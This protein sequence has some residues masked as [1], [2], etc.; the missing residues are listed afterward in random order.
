MAHDAITQITRQERNAKI[1]E[2][3]LDGDTDNTL[4]ERYGITPKAVIDIRKAH[5]VRSTDRRR[6]PRSRRYVDRRPISNLHNQIGN[7][8][9][10]KRE[11]DLNES[12]DR[13]AIEVNLST[14]RLSEIEFGL[15]DP[16]LDELRRIAEHLDVNLDY[17]IKERED[18]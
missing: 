18:T 17:L 7:R 2:E 9:R 1:V 3:F 15:K 13:M 12:C 8:I 16:K 11:L 14:K 5:G 10:E 4:A 6:K